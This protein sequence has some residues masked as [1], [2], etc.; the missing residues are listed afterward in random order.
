MKQLSQPPSVTLIFLGRSV[1]QGKYSIQGIE[2]HSIFTLYSEESVSCG[3][4]IPGVHC[5]SLAYTQSLKT[6]L[7]QWHTLT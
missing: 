3:R 7:K 2:E 6:I 5:T 4:R 1:R